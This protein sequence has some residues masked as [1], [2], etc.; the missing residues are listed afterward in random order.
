MGFRMPTDAFETFLESRMGKDSAHDIT[1]VRRV[2]ALAIRLCQVEDAQPKVVVPAAWLHDCVTL[3]K[4]AQNRHTA[5]T[6]AA[7][8]AIRERFGDR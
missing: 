5:S 7:E 4:D 6:L 1:H 8:A 3:S 2:V